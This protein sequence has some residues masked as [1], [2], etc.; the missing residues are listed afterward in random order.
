[1]ML[2]TD[3]STPGRPRQAKY[4]LNAGSA[5]LPISGITIFNSVRSLYTWLKEVKAY[6]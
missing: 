4:G 1:M 6:G 2:S 5:D 3:V